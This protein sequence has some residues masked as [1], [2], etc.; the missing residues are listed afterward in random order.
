MPLGTKCARN[1][2]GGGEGGVCL[3]SLGPK[4]GGCRRGKRGRELQSFLTRAF[5]Y[6]EEG[7]GE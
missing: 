1:Q 5:T 7:G 6:E 4:K 3:F 2:D